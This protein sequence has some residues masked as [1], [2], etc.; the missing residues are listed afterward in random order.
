MTKPIVTVAAMVLYEQGCFGLA[1]QAPPPITHT[2]PPQDLHATVLSTQSTQVSQYL[3][4]FAEPVVCEPW[5][6]G[7]PEAAEVE[8][9]QAP[10][11]DG[12]TCGLCRL[13]LTLTHAGALSAGQGQRR[14]PG[15]PA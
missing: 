15:G 2:L 8:Q 1:D 9:L 11:P 7:S 4:A 13:T 5:P 3:P 14:A 12:T 6:K 10:L